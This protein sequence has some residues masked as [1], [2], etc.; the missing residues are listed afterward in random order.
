MMTDMPAFGSLA[1]APQTHVS[2]TYLNESL[3]QM[4]TPNVVTAVLADYRSFDTL[5]ETIV[6]FTAGFACW[7]LG[8]DHK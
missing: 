8:V 5:M 4:H 7:L 1:A 6:I 3:A 2:P